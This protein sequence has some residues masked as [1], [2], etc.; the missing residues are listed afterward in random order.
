MPTN[1]SLS[2]RRLLAFAL[3]LAVVT[4]GLTAIPA[5]AGVNSW[6]GNGP[7]TAWPSAIA[8]AHSNPSVIYVSIDNARGLFKTT[9]GGA[10]WKD[11]TDPSWTRQPVNTVAVDPTNPN[12]VWVGVG[13]GGLGDSGLFRST[14]GGTDWTKLE[15]ATSPGGASAIAVHPT[16]G[17]ILYASGNGISKS[18]NGGNTWTDVSA[19]LPT[20]APAAYRSIY[21]IAID[22]KD[23]TVLYAG[24]QV[25]GVF[26]KIGNGNW[27]HIG[28]TTVSVVDVAMAPSTPT[29]SLVIAAPYNGG[30]VSVTKSGT[31]T[32]LDD[33]DLNSSALVNAV[34]VHPTNPDIIYAAAEQTVQGGLFKT[35]DG[36]DD[37]TKLD[38]GLGSAQEMLDVAINPNSTNTVFAGGRGSGVFK[39]T[40]GGAAW[41]R[42][43]IAASTV[44]QV[45][46]SSADANTAYA[47]VS[48][49]G[50]WKTTNGGA[51][52]SPR[53]NGMTSL[54]ANDVTI[55]PF[56][57]QT[58]YVGTFDSGVFK[59]EDGGANWVQSNVGLSE[60]QV[61]E[62]VVSR[63][64]PDILYTAATYGQTIQRSDN[65][66][67][68]WAAVT[69]TGLG[70]SYP[71]DLIVDP[72]DDTHLFVRTDEGIFESENSGANWTKKNSGLVVDPISGDAGVDALAMATSLPTTLYASD[73]E[74]LYISEDSADTWTATG[75]TG[76]IQDIVVDAGGPS[77][78]YILSNGKVYGS[79]DS[80]ATFTGLN[81]GLGSRYINQ[82]E[83]ND[84]GIKLYGA[85]AGWGVVDYLIDTVR[86]PRPVMT[87]PVSVP[88][89]KKSIPLAWT[90]SDVPGGVGSHH[91][92]FRKAR[93]DSGFGNKKVWK[94]G[95]VGRN[96][97]FP[98]AP[99]NT[100]CFSV[101]TK[102]R[103][104]L[105]SSWSKER[106][107]GLPV[108]DRALK[109][110]GTW[111]EH[112]GS[113]Y[114]LGTFSSATQRGAR[115]TLPGVKAKRVGL[116]ATTCASCGAVKV[117]LGTK[118]L[119][120]ISLKSGKRHERVYIPVAAF[121]RARTG[122]LSIVVTTSGKP[123]IIEGLGVF[124]A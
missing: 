20:Y 78:P 123:V 86:P 12:R 14:N 6:S 93:Y 23:P 96:V 71:A 21:S 63:S 7:T 85:T 76:T 97:R 54:N 31:Q 57:H 56:T 95:I 48:G 88:Q 62:V 27:T 92:R 67:D 82:L 50:V 69:N 79:I 83:I 52:W 36:G 72:D 64:D 49:G 15:D 80:G 102:D 44:T 109:T 73:G 19:G 39:T 47:A 26:Q 18:V 105:L 8:I 77:L 53:S 66:A 38:L 81:S 98:G 91:V 68:S 43:P 41:G 74:T 124:G 75:Y 58:A 104:G 103:G 70:G 11:V 29:E 4:I 45:D 33:T 13:N 10:T 16:N 60:T 40:N 118:V 37:W 114:Y 99:G 1:P 113:D 121:A 116:V 120:K 65:G 28:T 30:V 9:D 115:L 34:A 94:T 89:V 2:A 22:P 17:N 55:D 46:S 110:T 59:T 61:R 51:S 35:T 117:M 90:S 42:T 24:V 84:S 106:C 101:R 108:N 119:E 87:K 5:T 122:K 100:Y 32:Q 111:A 25:S 107:A 3:S 112:R